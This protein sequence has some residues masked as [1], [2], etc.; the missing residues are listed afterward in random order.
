MVDTPEH[1]LDKWL[2]SLIKS[3]VP[4]SLSLSLSSSLVDKI[5][6]LKPKNDL[7]LVS[8]GVTSLFTNVPVDL[9]I[10][11]I[12]NK[13]FSSNVAP[14]LPFPHSKKTIAQ[15]IW[16]KLLKLFTESML[17]RSGKLF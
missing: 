2:N 6:E 4:D 11:G 10:D 12:G 9:V 16:K 7:K 8:L 13:L 5:E 14:E 17:I 3:Y 1:N 15:N